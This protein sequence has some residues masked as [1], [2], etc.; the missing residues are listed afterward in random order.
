MKNFTVVETESFSKD[1][2]SEAMFGTNF[3]TTYD[4]EF[5][6]DENL[7]SVLKETGTTNLR[8]PGG[9]VTESVFTDVSFNTGIWDATSYVDENG[10]D[11]NL[12]SLSEFFSVASEVDAQVQLVIPTRVGFT[13][14]AGDAVLDGTY[15]SRTDLNPAYL[16]NVKG[17]IEQAQ[18]LAEQKEVTISKFEIG[19]EFWGS[20]IMTASEYGILAAKLTV[21][22]H[23]SYP[24]IGS[25]AQITCGANR[26]SP[27]SDRE[28]FLKPDLEGGYDIVMLN[29]HEGEV[30]NDWIR[31]TLPG[32]G[33]A[34]DQTKQIADQ[35]INF[36]NSIDILS[37]IVDHVYFDG[38]FAEIDEQRNY[39]LSYVPKT[40]K[41]HISS[42]E[43]EYFISE[44]GPRNIRSDDRSLNAGNASGLQYA[45]STVEAFFEMASF[46][47]DG[48]NFWPTTFG[49]PSALYRTLINSV[50]E[51]LTFGGVAFSWLSQAAINKKPLFDF[52]ID[53]Q[54]DIHGFESGGSMSIFAAERSGNR[55]E[56][57]SLNLGDFAPTSSYFTMI[58]T[59]NSDDGEVTSDMSSPVISYL[60]DEK[61]LDDTISFQLKA[62][63]L[64][65]LELQYITDGNDTI[66]GG[67]ADDRIRG[68]GGNDQLSGADGDDT[69]RG[70][71]GHDILEGGSGNDLLN[72][73]WGHDQLAG[74]LGNDVLI[75][76][77]NDDF[78]SGGNGSD[79]LRD[80]AGRDT[81]TGGQGAD[82]F[83]LS[84]DGESDTISDFSSTEDYID[85]SEWEGTGSPLGLLHEVTSDGCVLSSNDE[86]LIVRSIDFKPLNFEDIKF[87]GDIKVD[88]LETYPPSLHGDDSI[89]GDA[90]NDEL[91]GYAGA[92]VIE[93]GN[94][95]D[96]IWGGNGWDIL[97]GNSENDVIYGGDGYDT[98]SGGKHNDI[99]YGN[100]GMDIIYGDE[101]DDEIFGGSHS[102]VISGGTGN[103]TLEGGAGADTIF[104]GAN[105]DYMYGKAGSDI[106]EGGMGSD[107]ISG[108]INND[109]ITGGSGDDTMH[110]GNGSDLLEGG[111]GQDLLK[112]NSGQDTLDGGAGSDILVGG[113]G[114]DTFIFSSGFDRIVDFQNNIDSLVIDQSML[115]ADGITVKNLGF[116]DV[117]EGT[118]SLHLDFGSGN[119]LIIDDI[120]DLSIILDDISFI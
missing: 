14:S 114:A 7:L 89:R 116:F 75:G 99:L 101:G 105:N 60:S 88:A 91:K 67:I 104:G 46:G 18:Y 64:V 107:Y 94:G 20:G 66:S 55:D 33:S 100:F 37:G 69:V 103:D 10:A 49:Y 77:Q 87:L 3:V 45:H 16:E 29:E 53:G 68:G 84:L 118:D 51:N 5:F 71:L 15:G 85:I 106:L 65:W 22:L 47:V 92:D 95:D 113:I 13:T 11:K 117:S 1:V 61:N 32:Q 52:E 80:G 73:G 38:G 40:F 42:N 57:V 26:Y 56:V 27:S 50:D 108:G 2:V 34:T 112:G 120:H 9:S 19:N 4:Y 78:L 82:Y 54:I 39:A 109:I 111:N 110:G 93:G 43:L 90:T 24:D 72:G 17:Y 8:F 79:T 98:I 44:W 70:E 59:M 23:E 81:L 31:K 102:D 6:S 96:T 25:I 12:V 76:G 30:P 115:G 21:L 36:E 35:F 63:D 97:K 86:L 48:A 62:W 58:S 119:Y 41:A 74:G 28:V 83:V